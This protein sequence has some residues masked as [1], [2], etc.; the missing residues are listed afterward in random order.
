MRRSIRMHLRRTQRRTNRRTKRTAKA[1][2]STKS[3]AMRETQ[4]KVRRN[5]RRKPRRW[6]WLVLL[7]KVKPSVCAIASPRCPG[8]GRMLLKS[9]PRL[10]RR[11]LNPRS[12]LRRCVGSINPRP[13]R[14]RRASRSRWASRSSRPSRP[15]WTNR[16][17]LPSLPSSPSRPRSCVRVLKVLIKV[18]GFTICRPSILHL[19]VLFSTASELVI[20]NSMSSPLKSTASWRQASLWKKSK[21]EFQLPS[22]LWPRSLET[23]LSQQLRFSWHLW[24]VVWIES[25]KR[26]FPRVRRVPLLGLWNS[27]KSSFSSSILL[28]SLSHR[29]WIRWSPCTSWKAT[30]PTQSSSL[31]WPRTPPLTDEHCST[32]PYPTYFLVVNKLDNLL[33]LYFT[34]FSISS[35]SLINSNP[36]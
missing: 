11:M 33:L 25:V 20:E 6:S 34:Y 12:P 19:W 18:I 13:I 24:I 27:W 31:F 15:I 29:S 9:Q 17:S 8:D 14:A 32:L 4:A 5:P 1:M 21:L 26:W 35:T 10:K 23:S 2:R 36:L 16:P 7:L 3:T 30:M 22:K 28:F